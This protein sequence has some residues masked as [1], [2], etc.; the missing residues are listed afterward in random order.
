MTLV[1][2]RDSPEKESKCCTFTSVVGLRDFTEDLLKN[3]VEVAH[4]EKPLDIFGGSKGL[5]CS[6]KVSLDSFGCS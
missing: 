1:N 6:G 5:G 3:F 2:Y 4:V